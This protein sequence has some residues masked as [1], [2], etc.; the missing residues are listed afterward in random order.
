ML[1]FIEVFIEALSVSSPSSDET[2]TEGA[3]VGEYA[4]DGENCEGLDAVVSSFR[5]CWERGLEA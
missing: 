1:A 3:S 4:L 5:T 2:G